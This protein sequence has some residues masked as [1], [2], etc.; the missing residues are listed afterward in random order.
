MIR[1]QLMIVSVIL[2]FQALPAKSVVITDGF[3]L[4]EAQNDF[5]PRFN[6]QGSQLTFIST[7]PTS[8]GSTQQSPEL[9]AFHRIGDTLSLGADFQLFPFNSLTYQG[10]SYPFSEG[11]FH[12]ETGPTT[13]QSTNNVGTFN[14]AASARFVF[15]GTALG[16][17]APPGPGAAMPVE[18]PL[19]GQGNATVLFRGATETLLSAYTIRYDFQAVPEPSTWLMLGTGL[20][21]LLF[22][23]R[24]RVS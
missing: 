21:M 10:T 16:R 4:T 22:I 14:A 12:L 5:V 2:G 1:L 23:K 18:V 20:L 3:L 6:L 7:S 17:T 8:S 9:L 19:N 11:T 13:I 15:V 24:R